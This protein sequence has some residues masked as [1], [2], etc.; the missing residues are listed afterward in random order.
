MPDSAASMRLDDLER[1]HII[2]ILQ[3]AGGSRTRAAEILG[4]SR[5][6]LWDK[7]KRYGIF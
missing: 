1:R 6:T 5:S 3:R 7:G 4:I 2:Q